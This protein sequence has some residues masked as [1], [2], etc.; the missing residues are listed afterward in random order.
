MTM[1]HVNPTRM[2][3]TSLKKRLV[4][5]KRGHKLLKDKQDEL[6]KK[7]LDMVKQ[8]RALR[9]EV[10]AELIGAFKSFTMARSQMSANVVEE[11]LMI[12][13]AKVSI[14]VKKENIMSVNVPKLEILQEESKNLYPYGF[15]NTS[16]EMDAA[17][18]TLA[19]MLP[20]MLKLAELEKACQLM[21]D[22]IEKTRRRV[23][24]LEYVLIPQLE[25]TIK[26]ITMKLDENERS[27]RTRLMK[28]K[29]M[30]MKG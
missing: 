8:N 20:K 21:A 24:A 1:I 22:E 28:I 27:S 14:N 6:V 12:P 7:F 26:Y 18:R 15:A 13:S 10:E 9:E 17:I 16:A 11:S 3:L 5:A 29:E 19:T 30:V 23:N 2:E 4:T 25:N